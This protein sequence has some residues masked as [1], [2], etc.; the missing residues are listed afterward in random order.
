MSWLRHALDGAIG[1]NVSDNGPA[2]EITAVMPQSLF[3]VRHCSVYEACLKVS[4]LWHELQ[5]AKRK[6]SQFV[7]E[8]VQKRDEVSLEHAYTLREFSNLFR[9]LNWC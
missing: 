2:L 1:S 9:F 7:G 6:Q 4:T 8:G 3:L 5:A